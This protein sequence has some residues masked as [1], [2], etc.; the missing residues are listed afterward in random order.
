MEDEASLRKW[1]GHTDLTQYLKDK[2]VQVLLT[3]LKERITSLKEVRGV[4]AFVGFHRCD[5]ERSRRTMI[6]EETQWS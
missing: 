4:I 2:E 5:G 6:L 1:L 3:S